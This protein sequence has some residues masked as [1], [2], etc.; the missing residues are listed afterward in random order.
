MSRIR[1][2]SGAKSFIDCCEHL[3]LGDGV[4]RLLV[5]PSLGIAAASSATLAQITIPDAAALFYVGVARAHVTGLI[6]RTVVLA[7]RSHDHRRVRAG[8]RARSAVTTCGLICTTISGMAPD[9]R[10]PL[11]AAKVV[12]QMC[13]IS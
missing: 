1:S 10:I 5:G 13:P 9:N 2:R 8:G 4:Q 3:S 6:G 12:K 11:L 7:R